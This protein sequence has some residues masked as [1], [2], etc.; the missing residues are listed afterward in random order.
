MR[1]RHDFM[2]PCVGRCQEPGPDS[3]AGTWNRRLGQDD[4]LFGIEPNAWRREQGGR[5]AATRGKVPGA[6]LFVIANICLNAYPDTRSI[7]TDA[8]DRVV[9]LAAEPFGLR[10]APTRLRPVRALMP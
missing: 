3:P 1:F 2:P 5:R 9:D 6:F 8:D 10:A 4:L 7:P